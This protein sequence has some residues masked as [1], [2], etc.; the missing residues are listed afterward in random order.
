M[1]TLHLR[2]TVLPEGDVR[3]IWVLG[4]RLTFVRPPGGAT[5]VLDGGYL[6]PGLV[7]AHSHPGHEPAT[8]AF[9]ADRF[10]GAALAYAE[11]GTTLLRVPGHRAPIPPGLRGDPRLPRLVTAGEWL[12]WAGLEGLDG[13]QSVPADLTAAAVA[14]ARANDGWCKTYGDWE[15]FTAKTPVAML[16]ELCDAVHAAGGRVAAHCQTAEGTRNAVL[17]G[18]DSIEHAWYLTEDL[19]TALAARGGAVTPTWSGFLPLVADVRTKPEGERKAWFLDGVASLRTATVTA[20]ELGVTVLAGTDALDFGDVVTEIEHLIAAG[21]PAAAAVGAAS[22]DARRYLG[23]PGLTEG[24]PADLV[25][26][27]DDP[28]RTPAVLRHPA[29]VLLRGRRLRDGSGAHRYG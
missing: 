14:Q 1:E 17:A 9:D 19:L 24:A 2:G 12:A 13:P 26:V 29:L 15:P 20:H 28:R 10:T 8:M 25:A 18:V 23:F 6:L 4:D 5:T 16:T 11:A 21:L 7:D 22:W 3:D 27:P